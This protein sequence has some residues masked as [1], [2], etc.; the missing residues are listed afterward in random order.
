MLIVEDNRDVREMTCLMLS[1]HGFAVHAAE[2]GESGLHVA[3]AA[4]PDIALVDIDLPG[5]S[6]YEVARRLRQAPATAGIRLIAV[7]GYGQ[8]MDQEKARDAGFDRHFT[9]PVAIDELAHAILT[10]AGPTS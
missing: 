1:E 2:D 6:G 5:I 8:A 3:A 9:K 4:Q 7:T 10:L